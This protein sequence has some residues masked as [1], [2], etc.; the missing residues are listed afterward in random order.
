MVFPVHIYFLET[1]LTRLCYIPNI[2]AMKPCG[3]R[4]AELF[5][6]QNIYL[7]CNRLEPDEAHIKFSK[8]QPVSK[9]EMSYEASVCI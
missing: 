7:R 2:K 8:I 5:H 4:Q 1:M 6:F 3:F 9:E